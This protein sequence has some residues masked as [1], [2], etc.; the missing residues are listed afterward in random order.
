M[1]WINQ[2]NRKKKNISIKTVAINNNLDGSDFSEDIKN[3]LSCVVG[4]RE[5]LIEVETT[6]REICLLDEPCANYE[7]MYD[8]SS[9]TMTLTDK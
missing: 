1:Q 5:Q 8:Y 2:L 9:D 7:L 3:Q 6:E 4:S